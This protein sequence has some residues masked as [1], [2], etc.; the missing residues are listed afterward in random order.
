[1]QLRLLGSPDLRREDGTE[2][3]SVLAQPKRFALLAWLALAR[4]GG[5]QRRDAIIAMFWPEL[6]TEHARGALRKTV[7]HLRRA[8]GTQIIANRGGEE[9]GLAPQAWCDAVALEQAVVAGR[10]REAVSLY[11]GDLLPGFFLS[12]VPEFERWLDG[13]RHRLRQHAVAAAWNLAEA[14]EAQQS[15]TGLEWAEWAFATAPDNEAGLR[16]LLTT[17]AGGGRRDRALRVYDAYRRRLLDE[18]AAVPAAETRVLIEGIRGPLAVSTAADHAVVTDV[19]AQPAGHPVPAPPKSMVP[20][21]SAPAVGRPA[22]GRRHRFR[23]PLTAAA[24]LVLM[25]LT[26]LGARDPVKEAATRSGAPV[27]V[28][29][30]IRHFDPSDSTS[31]ADALPDLLATNLS[32]VPHVRVLSPARTREAPTRG[33]AVATSLAAARKA[34]ASQ[35]I[36]GALYRQ[37]DGALRLDLRRVRVS[38]ATV[39]SSHTVVDTNVFALVDGATMQILRALGNEVADL[40]VTEVTTASLVAYRFYQQGLRTYYDGDMAAAQRLFDAALAEDSTFAMAAYHASNTVS[41]SWQQT[42]DYLEH[43]VRMLGHAAP[44]ASLQIR[45]RWADLHN[46]PARLAIADTLA[47]RYPADPESHL[48]LGRMQT[49]A[50]DFGA[51]IPR[52]WSVLSA[53]SSVVTAEHA[54]CTACDAFSTLVTAYA[55]ADSMPAAERA[56]REW[57]RRMPASLGAL[58][59]LAKTLEYQGR[60]E[61]ALDVRRSA[62]SR[63]ASAGRLGVWLWP[64]IYAIRAGDW[65]TADSFLAMRLQLGTADEQ[66]EALWYMVISLRHQRRFDDALAAARR[67]RARSAT[68]AAPGAPPPTNALAE[69]TV[70]FEMGRTRDAA[71]LWDSLAVAPSD[72]WGAAL[73]ARQYAWTLTH[74]ATALHAAADTVALKLLIPRIEVWGRQ[75]A[76]G[77]DPRLHHHARGLLFT[78]RGDDER[79]AAAFRRAIFSSTGGHTRTNLELA[80]TLLRL[81]R[82]AEAIPILQAAFRGPLEASNM[83]VTHTDL[84]EALARAFA[85]AGHSDSAASH[86]CWVRRAIGNSAVNTAWHASTTPPRCP[87]NGNQ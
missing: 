38:D 36:E 82:P 13:E 6:D 40:H 62:S 12:D 7:Y 5:F 65:A 39:L 16:R 47:T 41:H 75:S 11:R 44:R 19:P 79:A 63:H 4:P 69:A 27:V 18:F 81:G 49:W 3:R 2:I 25:V 20:P 9:L 33:P 53:D 86:Y 67:L 17:L 71:L 43:A 22:A 73:Q 84:H 87:E 21:A 85:M 61:E 15:G 66:R 58:D 10:W 55:L 64:A 45:A 29:G 83:Y 31:I 72:R 48:L 70:L 76:Y 24:A 14:A 60:L 37:P 23:L 46:E 50:G 74:A 59:A 51:A 78:A 1:M 77:R 80:R 52:L 26:I 28:I 34:G 35:L 68:T 8:L 32:R 54:V 30:Q 42:R 56:A 57:V